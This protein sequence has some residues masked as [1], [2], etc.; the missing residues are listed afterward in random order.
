[1]NFTRIL[2]AVKIIQCN[3][4]RYLSS[5]HVPEPGP[6]SCIQKGVLRSF[7]TSFVT[8]VHLPFSVR[9]LDLYVASLVFMGSSVIFFVY[10]PLKKIHAFSKRVESV[11]KFP[12]WLVIN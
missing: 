7:R 4:K 10:V 2:E 5:M 9:S 3:P 12:R 8:F 1:M 11:E 6:R